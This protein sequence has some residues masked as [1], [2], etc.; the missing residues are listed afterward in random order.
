[1]ELNQ[2][3]QTQRKIEAITIVVYLA[4]LGYTLYLLFPFITQNPFI[5]ITAIIAGMILADLATGIIHWA[6][7][8][9]GTPTWPIVGNALIRPFREHHTNQKA[10][11]QHDFIE[12]NGTNSIFSLPFILLALWFHHT[13]Q[14]SVANTLTL[15][16]LSTAIFGFGTN[17][18]HKW[19]HMENPPK[20]IELLQKSKIILPKNHH[21]IHHTTPFEHHY[22]I[23]NGW[24][25]SITKKIHFYRVLEWIITKTTGAIP[26]KSDYEIIQSTKQA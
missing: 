4:L 11:T 23:T 3:N 25:N 15:T 6:G 9:W 26:R 16:F 22:A 7:D 19:A 1:M 17:Q 24:T 13:Y 10:I 21:T 14:S 20:F 12:T 2:Y 18:F 8:T 5:T